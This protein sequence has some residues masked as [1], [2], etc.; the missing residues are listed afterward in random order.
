MRSE[1]ILRPLPTNKSAPPDAM[2]PD[3]QRT[4]PQDEHSLKIMYIVTQSISSRVKGAEVRDP[5]IGKAYTTS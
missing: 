4:V 1:P 3:L 2:F 5:Q